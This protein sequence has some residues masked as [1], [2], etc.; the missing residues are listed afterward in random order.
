[1]GEIRNPIQSE[2]KE[3]VFRAYACNVMRLPQAGVGADFVLSLPHLEMP[4]AA[5]HVRLY[6]QGDSLAGPICSISS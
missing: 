1:M 6:F 2:S 3:A 4:A 5:C